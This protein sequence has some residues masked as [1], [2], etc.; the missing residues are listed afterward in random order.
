MT[1]KDPWVR[2]LLLGWLVVACAKPAQAIPAFARKYQFSCSTCHAPFPRLK[3]YGEEFA[4]RGFRLEDP[5]QEPTRATYDVG[6]PWLELPRELGLAVRLDGFVSLVDSKGRPTSS[7]V[8]W[9]WA[10]KLLSGGPITRNISYYVYGILEKGESVK[11]EDTWVQFN[12]LFHLPID[13]TVG[14][15]QVS[16]PLFKRELRLERNDYAM[17]SLQVGHVPTNLTYDRGLVLTWRAPG[18]VEVLAQ[19][20]NGNGIEPAEER[21]DDNRFKA[22]SL[23]LVRSFGP[24]RLGL[25]GYQGRAGE[26]NG[27][28]DRVR[29]LGPDLVVDLGQNWQLSACYLRRTDDDPFLV[30]RRGPSFT[31]K[32]GFLELHYFPHGQDGRWVVTLLANRVTSDVPGVK[33]NNAS[34]TVNYLRARNFRIQGELLYDSVHDQNVLT[35]GVVTAF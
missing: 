12:S 31:T 4:A 30:G 15:F 5:A 9:P 29:Y 8:E 13:L 25:F 2:I 21:F 33:V 7:D 17:L 1:Q 16:D 23:R 22:L 18:E 20:V 35:L 14:Q 10:F 32:G 11:L 34:L 3:P 26:D 28:Q 6:D 19:V 24:V 27:P